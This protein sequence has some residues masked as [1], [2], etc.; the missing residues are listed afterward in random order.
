M[1]VHSNKGYKI[2]L[3]G[4][5]GVGKSSLVEMLIHQTFNEDNIPTIGAAF[6][7]KIFDVDNKKIKLGIWDTAGQERFR[8]LAPIYYKDALSCICVFSMMDINSF[9]HV[10]DW[11]NQYNKINSDYESLIYIVA[12]K[13]DIDESK[14]I[15]T[16][17]KINQLSKLT[18][19]PIIF[20]SARNMESVNS[21]FIKLVHDIIAK[22][23]PEDFQGRYN[24]AFDDKRWI[25][26][27][28]EVDTIK[29]KC[30][31]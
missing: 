18:S 31:C 30:D 28:K 24:L 2:V 6:Y 4:D 23:I 8:S 5:S 12:N 21:L 14:W 22:N 27:D 19:H 11:I 25:F 15:V 7:S 10:I 29:S 13:M 1:N 3:N 16:R 26:S 20:T 9:E 17:D